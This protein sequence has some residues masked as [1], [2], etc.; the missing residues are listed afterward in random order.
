M[1]EGSLYTESYG[2]TDAR[3]DVSDADMVCCIMFCIGFGWYLL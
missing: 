1:L 2:G 3:D